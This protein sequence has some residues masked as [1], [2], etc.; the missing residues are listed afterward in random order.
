MNDAEN[1]ISRSDQDG[2]IQAIISQVL[3]QAI[4]NLSLNNFDSGADEQTPPPQIYLQ[5]SEHQQVKTVY[6]RIDMI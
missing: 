1:Q 3:D 5:A 2:S 4:G 6:K